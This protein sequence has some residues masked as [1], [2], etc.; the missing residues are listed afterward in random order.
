MI[1]ALINDA[2]ASVTLPKYVLI[3]ALDGATPATF[4]RAE[5]PH[6]DRP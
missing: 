5:T 2:E 6:I 1:T 3:V 4:K